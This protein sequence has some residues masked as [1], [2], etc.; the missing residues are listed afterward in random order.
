MSSLLE[1]HMP[2][3][4]VDQMNDVLIQEKLFLVKFIRGRATATRARSGSGTA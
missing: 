1:W 3:N 4:V 2:K